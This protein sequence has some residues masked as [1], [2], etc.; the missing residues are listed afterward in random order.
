[1]TLPSPPYK[2]GK[3]MKDKRLI[4]FDFTRVRHRDRTSMKGYWLYSFIHYL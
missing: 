1:M 3:G 4:T 2:G